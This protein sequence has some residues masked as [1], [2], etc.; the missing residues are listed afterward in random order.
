MKEQHFSSFSSFFFFAVSLKTF[1]VPLCTQFINYISFFAL[2]FWFFAPLN[3]HSCTF[4]SFLKKEV[5]LKK[6]V[7]GVIHCLQQCTVHGKQSL[8]SDDDSKF[9]DFW[10]SW[11]HSL[12]LELTSKFCWSDLGRACVLIWD[13]S[14]KLQKVALLERLLGSPQLSGKAGESVWADMEIRHPEGQGWHHRPALVMTELSPLLFDSRHPVC[15]ASPSD[16][17][18][19]LQAQSPCWPWKLGVVTKA[20]SP[21]S[22][23]LG[24]FRGSRLGHMSL[25]HLPWWE[26]SPVSPKNSDHIYSRS[27]VIQW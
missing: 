24:I 15:L 4:F 7:S 20:G 8:I 11:T 10:F 26:A 22:P 3:L 16:M 14:S 19:G 23:P 5:T 18:T 25:S 27:S 2:V 21:W 6:I 17:G 12:S 9:G 1:S 13:F